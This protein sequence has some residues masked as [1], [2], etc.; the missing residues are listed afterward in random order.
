MAHWAVVVP[1]ERYEAERLF[2]HDTLELTGLDEPL[3]AVGDRVAL[4]AEAEP[5][6]FALGRV[7]SVGAD[8]RDPDDPGAG[9]A[10]TTLEIAYTHRLFDAPLPADGVTGARTGAHPI[11]P[12]RF[13][14]F[15]EKAGAVPVADREWLVGVYLPIEA[16]SPGEAVR[17]FWTYVQQLGPRELPAY[18]SPLG[19]ELAMQ[20][21]VL[22]EVTNLD[23]EEDDDED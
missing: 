20:A 23:P 2:R 12:D 13:A 21:Y 8:A 10:G 18:V 17:A 16:A 7:V 19:D 1:D 5:V 6:V 14:A 15:V 4:V 11:D 22:G 3:P 9:G